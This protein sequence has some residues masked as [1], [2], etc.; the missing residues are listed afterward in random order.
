MRAASIAF[1]LLAPLAAAP[2]LLKA[3]EMAPAA[4]G[5][6]DYVMEA[7]RGF[8]TDERVIITAD[9]GR[10]EQGGLSSLS[11]AVR[12]RQGD[13]EFSASALDY[14]DVQ[15]LVRVQVDSLFRNSDF[16]IKSREA[17]FDLSAGSGTFDGTEFT[18]SARGAHGRA[19]SVTLHDEGTAEIHG[20]S[21]TTCTPG[22]ESWLLSAG[23][24]ELDH[25]SGLGTAEHAVLRLGGVPLFYVPWIQFPIDD[26]RRSGLLFPAFGETN[27]TGVEFRQPIYVNIAPNLD[28]TVIPRWMQRRGT[29]LGLLSRYL[30]EDGTG[31]VL[32]EYLPEDHVTREP[33]GYLKSHLAG[34]VNERLSYNMEIGA[35]TDKTYFED[36]GGQG[37]LASLTHLERAARLTYSVPAAY[38]LTAMAQS[39]QTIASRVLAARQPYARLPQITFRARTK[40]SRY[41]TRLG[42]DGEYVSFIRSNSVEGQRLDL[43]PLIRTERDELSWYSAA[44]LDYRYT[45]YDLNNTEPGQN[46][47]PSRGLPVFSAESGLRFDRITAGG[48]LQT[49]EPYLYYL[50]APFREQS[51]LPIFDTGQPDFDYTQLFIRN[52]FSG[53]DRISDANQFAVAARSRLL[54]PDSGE[55]RL[56]FSVGQLLRI[57][58]SRVE[59]PGIETPRSGPTDFFA[60]AQ[61]YLSKRL[62]AQIATAWSPDDEEFNRVG[63]ALHYRDEQRRAELGYRYRRD[64]L[65]QADFAA[66]LPL[67]DNWR[68]ALRTRYSLRDEQSLDNLAGLEYESCCYAVR[69][70]YR[71]FIANTAGDFNNGVYLQLELKGLTRMGSGF[72]DLLATDDPVVGRPQPLY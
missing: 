35:T 31:T 6:A 5:V 55:V 7:P 64:L 4:C 52:R 57:K 19:D 59:V 61:Y 1:F 46:T 30:V 39:Y 42:F 56:A 68:A 12:L 54:E 11:G 3:A 20:G 18:L 70:S 17:R 62:S 24:I 49:L 21:Y 53:E 38:T 36:L 13:R 16:V 69:V 8:S 67:L 9:E 47:H 26:R 41:R 28:A 60:D 2:L 50:Y 23:N 66:S 10:L 22:A 48:R 40:N 72:E 71:R 43:N 44:Q 33:R 27:A 37:D 25:E 51:H 58:P 32:M 65:E 34:L 29:Q 15:K 63:L 45:L 14:D